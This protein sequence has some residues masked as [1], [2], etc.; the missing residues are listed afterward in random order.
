VPSYVGAQVVLRP[1][2]V[3][4]EAPPAASINI[5]EPPAVQPVFNPP[6]MYFFHLLD[7]F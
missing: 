4:M 7:I 5:I 1:L 3:N 2:V 6:S